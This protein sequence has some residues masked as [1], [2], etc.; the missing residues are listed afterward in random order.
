MSLPTPIRPPVIKPFKTYVYKHVNNTKL[1]V[2]VYLPST[3]NAGPLLVALYI[4]GGGWVSVN[5]ADYS[6]PLFHELLSYNFVI[7]YMDY[8]LSP[9]TPFAEVKKD[10]MAVETWVRDVLPSEMKKKAREVD[11]N[12]VVVLGGSA[13]GHLAL[14]TPN[15][16]KYPPSAIVSISAPT[17][18]HNIPFLNRGRL[19]TARCPI[20]N[21]T[22][23]FLASATDYENPPSGFEILQNAEDYERPRRYL[24]L[25]IFREGIVSEVLLRGLV[26]DEDGKLRLPEKGS[27]TEQEIDDIS[28]YHICTKNYPPTCLV[29]G[30]EDEVFDLSHMLDFGKKLKCYDIQCE[31]IKAEGQGHAFDIWAEIDGEVHV[32][33]LRPAL[34]WISQVVGLGV[35]SS[36]TEDFFKVHQTK[37]KWNVVTASRA[38]AAT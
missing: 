32:K 28:P 20:P 9:E 30:T 23:V 35:G 6:R 25:R 15:L 38:I 11:G 14:L 4:P 17:D 18:M 37:W 8:R 21:C 29:M 16:W 12:K 7:C 26:K 19:S 33:I 34:K 2:D 1:Y 22:P 13:G 3:P 5:R 24:G 31:M 10:V 36:L 27:V